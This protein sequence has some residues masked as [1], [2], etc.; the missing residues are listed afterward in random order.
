[1]T[2]EQN[3]AL[4][5]RNDLSLTYTNIISFAAVSIFLPYILSAIVLTFL[6]CY[7]VANKYTRQLI[8]VHKGSWLL[9]I[10]FVYV[11]AVPFLY[12][13]WMGLIVGVGM[14]MAMVFGL[15]L[16]SVMTKELYE[17]ILNLI[18]IMS[19]T[20]TAYAVIE[21]L[22]NYLTDSRHSHRIASVFSHPNYFGTVVGTVIIICAYKLL[23]KQGNKFFYLMIA[24]ANVIS[25]YLCKSMSVWMEVFL[26]VLVLLVVLKYYRLT[27]LWVST[28][29]L[30]VLLIFGFNLQLI[31]RLS[32]METT[33]GI[34][35]EI[36]T[37]A[38]KQL[39]AAPWFGH[40]FMSF[41]FLCNAV[42]RGNMIPHSHNIYLDML[43]NFGIVGSALLIGFIAISYLSI[44]K[45]RFQEKN[46]M[47]TSLILA[48][49]VAALVHG[50]T[51]LTLLW[52][53]TFPL[54]LIILSGLGADEKNGRYHINTDCFF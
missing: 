39:E 29:M 23:T 33:V 12:K 18:C 2:I 50:A 51:D 54:F 6:A 24:A 3:I 44:L 36:W 48:V 11:L 7:I 4:K 5:R 20:S 19:M 17:R 38:L 34:R 28:A 45:V 13:N 26:G 21:K 15:F 53:Q 31:P 30:G 32:D 9:K 43:L 10:F 22:M 42:Y 35:E 37:L 46:I 47:I 25:I 49:T 16:R 27:L 14:I 40:G 41:R 1:M 52:I 8:F